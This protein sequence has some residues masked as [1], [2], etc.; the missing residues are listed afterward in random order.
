MKFT[1]RFFIQR[2][3]CLFICFLSTTAIHGQNNDFQHQK[4]SLLKV[5]ASTKGKEKLEIYRELI[6][7]Q[8]P[9]EEID[10]RLQYISDFIREAR[11]QKNKEYESLA[12]RTELAC[13]FHSLRFDEYKQKANEYLPF[14]KKN[15]SRKNYYDVLVLQA[16]LPGK[17]GKRKIEEVKQMYE[18]AKQEDCLY[19]IAQATVLMAQMYSREKRYEDA[20]KYY[21]E[22]IEIALKLIKEEPDQIPNYHLA[23]NGYNGLGISLRHQ[24][25]IDELIPLTSEWKKRTMAFE[26]TFGYPDPYLINYYLCY[27]QYNLEKEKY[28]VVELYCDSMERIAEPVNLH[29]AWA[30]RAEV[31]EQRNEYDKAIGWTDKT[32]DHSTNIGQLNSTVRLLN[33]KALFL[34]KMGRAEESYLVSKKAFQLN[35]SIRL[36]ANN[37]Q[38]DEIRTQYEVDKY[39]AEKER[40]R[41]I[42]FSLIGGCILLVIALG[43]WIFYS[44]KVTKKN[45][46]LAQQIKEMAAQQ[47]E[48]INE[49]LDKTSFMPVETLR[50]TSLQSADL[51][52]ENRMDKLCVAIRDRLLKDKIYRDPTI[53]QDDEIRNLGT[54]KRAFN[55]AMN[56]CFKMSFISYINVLR[57][58]DAVQLLEQSDL[59]I[60]EISD[61]IGF[62][63]SL[64]FRRQFQA[65]YNMNPKDYRNLIK[66]N[67][68]ISVNTISTE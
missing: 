32:I 43:I 21:R 23:S 14:L 31:C 33:D 54:N 68:N 47:E 36:L 30:L 22:T 10:L 61:M 4:D 41:I 18:E 39:V 64:T 5:I 49:I 27:S 8:F 25:K 66:T 1:P 12:Y 9:N 62:G 58:R 56:L 29:Y 48:R 50:A 13:L 34:S 17:D 11:K 55:K 65:K 35:D 44:R 57:L 37:A 38:L 67:G 20:E 26:K 63:S 24:R 6:R 60:E 51:C 40:Q 52:V 3:L 28:D 42:I 53:T 16:Q 15:G 59:Q 7:L 45:R 19:G 2:L 46:Q